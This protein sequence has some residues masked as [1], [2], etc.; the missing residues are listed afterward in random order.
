MHA[1]IPTD[2]QRFLPHLL[3]QSKLTAAKQQA[4]KNSTKAK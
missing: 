3:A 2:S 1:D 4:G